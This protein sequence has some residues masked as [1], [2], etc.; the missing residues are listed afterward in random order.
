M[1]PTWPLNLLSEHDE[2]FTWNTSLRGEGFHNPA[3][4]LKQCYIL[5]MNMRESDKKYNLTK[6]K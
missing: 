5:F 4:G 3:L 1:L 2:L 6:S